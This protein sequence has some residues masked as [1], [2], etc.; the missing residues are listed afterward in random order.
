MIV[1]KRDGKK[2]DF[3]PHKIEVA[4][5]KAFT[6]TRNESND[7]IRA[8]AK[9]IA[10]EIAATGKDISVEDIQDIVEEKQMA[11]EYK[12]VAKAYVEYRYRHK[13]I[14]E[15][16]TTDQSIKELLNGE[17]DYWNNENSNKNARVVTTH[18]D[19][20]AGITST[21]ISRRLL[22]PKDV[23]EAHDAGIIH[24]HDIDYFA[25]RSLHNCELLNLE[26]VLQNGTVLNGVM[27]KKPHRL[28]T[29]TTI[30]TQV[31]TAVTS[32]SYGG[33]TINLSHLAP[34]VRDSYKL[35]YKKYIDRG[36]SEDD[37]KKWADVDLKKE[38]TD[39]VQ[40]FNYQVNSMTNTNG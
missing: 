27:I 34:F 10:D 25:Q 29:A 3:D 6:E 19:Y 33:C 2:V 22:L 23:V 32:S 18:R 39:S 1:I 20:I 40:T 35:H 12:D 14:R 15:F 16:N 21:D 31:I 4:I 26:D 5:L 13:L 36:C 8:C 7:D 24:F 38:V 28:L 11:T 37:A 17:S 30:A 9:R